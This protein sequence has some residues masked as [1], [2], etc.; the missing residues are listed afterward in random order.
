M[1]SKLAPVAENV[2]ES[3]AACLVTMVQGNIFAV[4]MTHVAIA[5]STGLGAGLLATAVLATVRAERRATVAL[6]L[7]AITALIDF[8]MHPGGFGPAW[9]EAAVTGLV[10][11][12][13]SWAGAL[14]LGRRRSGDR[15]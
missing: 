1:K 6:G 12:A 11:G 5:S 8:A 4:S 3:A 9:A 13:L 2:C 14:A 7:G 10:A 15:S